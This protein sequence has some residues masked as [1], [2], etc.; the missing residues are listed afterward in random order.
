MNMKS[1]VKVGLFS[2][3]IFLAPNVFGVKKSKISIENKSGGKI[4]A[5][6]Y[7]YTKN[8]SGSGND[9]SWEGN[10][11][12]IKPHIDF[13]TKKYIKETDKIKLNAGERLEVQ[14]PQSKIF[15]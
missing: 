14:I 2:A 12:L 4:Y 5:A 11:L 3:S 9:V 7:T 8:Y 10:G 6:L 1:Y 15:F 13:I